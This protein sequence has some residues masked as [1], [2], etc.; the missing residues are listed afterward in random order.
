MPELPSHQ[1]EF[2]NELISINF[3]SFLKASKNRDNDI[4]HIRDEEI[5]TE[6]KLF[7]ESNSF[8]QFM[9]IA[10]YKDLSFFD[11]IKYFQP[12]E[13]AKVLACLDEFIQAAEA[14][15]IESRYYQYAKGE[16]N[17]GNIPYPMKSFVSMTNSNYIRESLDNPLPADI[18]G[19][20]SRKN[21]QQGDWRVASEQAPEAISEQLRKKYEI[22]KDGKL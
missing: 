22:P 20:T 2:Q 11:S 3:D 10:G 16:I 9:K 13:I 21:P 5:E 4:Y 12:E 17:R 19:F 14:N 15:S 6:K 1:E 7:E 18:Y 8:E